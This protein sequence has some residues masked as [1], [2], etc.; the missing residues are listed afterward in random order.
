MTIDVAAALQNAFSLH[1][2]GSLE[3]ACAGY[4]RVLVEN[5][6]EVN[7]LFLLGLAE[8]A[9]SP[10]IEP[11]RRV[12]RALRLTPDDPRVIAGLDQSFCTVINHYIARY[13]DS[14]VFAETAEALLELASRHPDRDRDVLTRNLYR[15][16]NASLAKDD[17]PLAVRCLLMARHR[18]DLGYLRSVLRRIGMAEHHD[19]VVAAILGT[20][21]DSADFKPALFALDGLMSPR[22]PGRDPTVPRALVH[23]L[24]GAYWSCLADLEQTDEAASADMQLLR[25]YALR[26][27]GGEYL[28]S[29]A[30]ALRLDPGEA[31]ALSLMARHFL[32]SGQ[33]AE[34]LRW[35]LR[36][37]QARPNHYD[38]AIWVATCALL[39]D[40]DT[41]AG[42][43][44]D[45]AEAIDPQ[46]PEAHLLRA[47][48]L[49]TAD[50][51]RSFACSQKALAQLP[52]LPPSSLRT[53]AF[54]TYCS[55]VFRLARQRADGAGGMA[56]RIPVTLGNLR[57]LP[58]VPDDARFHARDTAGKVRSLRLGG[59]EIQPLR[60]P[61][62]FLPDLHGDRLLTSPVF[63]GYRCMYEHFDW[64]RQS[65]FPQ[66]F[67]TD[68]LF[69]TEVADAVL[70]DGFVLSGS[71]MVE[72]AARY[73]E[74]V[75]EAVFLEQ[76]VMTAR[77]ASAE[78]AFS[79][80]AG[81]PTV[82]FN[83]PC[84]W[85]GG[86]HCTTRML[87]Y[88]VWLA[89]IA[90]KL[91]F[92][93]SRPETRDL[94]IVIS[95]NA[96][97][98]PYV[99]ETLDALG[100][101]RERL[102]VIDKAVLSFSTLYLIE[103]GTRI[104]TPSNFDWLRQRLF[105]V[106]GITPKP[107]KGKRYYLSRGDAKGR[108]VLNERHLVDALAE[109]GFTSVES[110]PLSLEQ[111]VRL[112]SEAEAIIGINGGGMA[113]LLF[114]PRGAKVLELFP[115][116]FTDPLYWMV[117]SYLEMDYRISTEENATPN[118]DFM[119]SIERVLDICRTM[120]LRD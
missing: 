24:A 15:V 102:I 79:V 101:P 86:F 54:R 55:A 109:F 17:H 6:A 94:P 40:D 41:L 23:F 113:N 85:L 96:M 87:Q 92:F 13:N 103:S 91:R 10:G 31:F 59:P 2:S 33:P 89:D 27:T 111:R 39:L 4:R 110:T 108:R 5:P 7:A 78:F 112:F 107:V 19:G 73:D 53:D 48:R 3:P 14:L 32:I 38:A 16:A 119:V 30:L 69:L 29:L 36:L 118:M 90:P 84:A 67:G 97:R 50:P 28:A 114:A 93:L 35:A 104:H 26:E 65:P 68:G 61:A 116:H 105:G 83:G 74:I 20:S 71:E 106:F 25:A 76:P 66:Y 99:R 60:M 70:H 21:T 88:F 22:L 8:L 81:A 9:L 115:A 43:W 1:R 18:R 34:A 37:W 11:F 95:K 100:V 51:R 82:H 98:T 64:Q 49:R 117:A 77:N 46:R 58:Q 120:G 63:N 62:N 57:P 56:D 80:P 47:E 72:N 42:R 52:G 45:T 12:S 75:L 44:L